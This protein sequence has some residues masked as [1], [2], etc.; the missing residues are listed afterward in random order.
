MKYLK[1][2]GLL[3]VTVVAT[4]GFAGSASA[5]FTSPTGTEYTG[6]IDAT[7]ESSLLF[8]GGFEVTCTNSTAKGTVTTN[9]TNHAS[10]PLSALSFSGC[11]GTVHTLNLGSLTFFGDE[12][13]MTGST[14]TVERSGISC[15]YWGSGGTKIGTATNTMINGNDAVTLDISANLP[16]ETGSFLCANTM[17]WT[18]SYT[19]T[20]P[21][22][23]FLDFTYARRDSP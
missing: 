8:K 18:G 4:M 21:A 12:L 16:K 15:T 19:I 6:E 14:V 3:A 22:S 5:T 13:V 17:S 11:N 23:S 10:G 7:A 2:I 9:D 20:T 1:M